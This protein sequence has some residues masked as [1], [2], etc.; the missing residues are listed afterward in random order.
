L[1]AD[2]EPKA[3]VEICIA[4]KVIG[5]GAR[6]IKKI[7]TPFAKS[8]EAQHHSQGGV[9]A[10]LPIT[11]A[12]VEMHGGSIRIESESGEGTTVWIMLPP[13]D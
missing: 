12:L 13:P 4:D 5:T 11:R 10:G 7:M 1:A 2:L 3:S 8:D 9:G 6:N